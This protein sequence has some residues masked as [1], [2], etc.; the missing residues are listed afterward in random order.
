[1]NRLQGGQATRVSAA[2]VLLATGFCRGQ[3]FGRV[4]LHPD[5]VLKLE[6]YQQ[7]SAA[8]IYQVGAEIQAAVKAKL[9][10]LLEP[11]IAFWGDFG[12]RQPGQ[13]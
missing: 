11:E 6:N 12:V 7:A 4:R 13:I 9:G 3:I 10:I 2:L 1:M 8:E 5:H